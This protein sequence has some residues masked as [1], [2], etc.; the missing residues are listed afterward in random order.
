MAFLSYLLTFKFSQ[1]PLETLFSTIRASLGFNNNPTVI[2]FT[3]AFKKILLGAANRSNYS[4][5][6][7]GYYKVL[8]QTNPKHCID[9]ILDHYEHDSDFVD[10]YLSSNELQITTKK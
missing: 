9:T 10:L 3:A 4:N 5:S 8:V 6:S 1:D 7:E 2:Q